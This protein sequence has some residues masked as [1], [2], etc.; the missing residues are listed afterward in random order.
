MRD[1]LALISLIAVIGCGPTALAPDGFGTGDVDAGTPGPDARPQPPG[2]AGDAGACEDAVDVV[3]VLDTSSSMG[4]VLSQ[5]EDQIDSVVAAAT[6]LAPDPHFGLVVFQDN[7]WMDD[8][9]PLAGGVVHTDGAALQSAFFHYRDVYTRKDRNP[10]DGPTGPERQNPVCEENAL[11]ALYMAADQF[12][13]RDSAT[14]VIILATDDTFLERPDNYGDRDADGDTTS[15]D[16]PSEGDYPAQYTL[17]ETLT[18]LR[19]QR[20]RVFTFTRLVE[21]GL[22]DGRCGTGRRHPWE[23]IRWGWTLPYFGEAP[24]PEQTDASNF[25]IDLVRTGMLSLSET[26][27]Q[28]VLESHCVPPVL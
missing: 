16:F 3:F 22:F 23:S 25:D 14:R 5:L 10:G 8:T 20:V 15:T 26:I 9:G 18:R 2:P 12:P 19:D 28:V 7:A 13:W 4:F 6:E 1:V 27:N 17:A 11:D 24:I 21:P